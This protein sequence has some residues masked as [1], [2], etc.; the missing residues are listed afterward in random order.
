MFVFEYGSAATVSAVCNNNQQ[1]HT[2]T[3]ATKRVVL[4]LLARLKLD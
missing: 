1:Q 2:Q 4:S 3:A